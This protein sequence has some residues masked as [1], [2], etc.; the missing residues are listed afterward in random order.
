V[1]E[2]TRWPASLWLV[3]H[4]LSAGNLAD[5][6]AKRRGLHELDLP[7]RDMD[8]PLSA[9]GETQARMT[10]EWIA[11]EPEDRRPRHTLS[12]PYVRAEQT[13]RILLESSGC[14]PDC[15]DIVLD[16]RLREREFGILDRLTTAGIEQRHPEQAAARAFLGKFYHRPPGGESWAD[17][18][19]RLR[20]ALDTIGREYAGEHLLVVT[21]QV[22]IM[23]FRYLLE[24]LA[25]P[26][27][28]AIDRANPIANCSITVYEFDPDAGP[29]GGLVLR[30]FNEVPPGE[31]VTREDDANVAPR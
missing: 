3:R 14:P 6:D 26:D 17:V 28:L 16:E 22:A 7:H 2:P 19:L 12:S 25:E 31:P 21:H 9:T 29:H 13:A 27:L 11:R 5:E 8:V 20:S 10:G 4:G 18:A 30:R 23:V 1:P 24:R 15:I